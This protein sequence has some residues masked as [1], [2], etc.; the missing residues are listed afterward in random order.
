MINRQIAKAEKAEANS[1]TGTFK[2]KDRGRENG[3]DRDKDR[4]RNSKRQK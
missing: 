1:V 2:E 4:L 3:R